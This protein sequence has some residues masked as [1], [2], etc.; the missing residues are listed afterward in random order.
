MI[1][2]VCWKWRPLVSY[3][4]SKFDAGHVNTLR[5]MV[6]RHYQKPH[7]FNCITDDPKGI[8][9]RVRIIPLWSDHS[10]LVSLHGKNNPSC[11]RR[12]RVFARDAAD[13]IGPRFI[14]IDLD[15]VI[16]GDLVPIFDRP[17]DFVMW[18][19][20]VGRNF[21]NGSMFMMTAGARPQVWETFEPVVS[22]HAASRAG[23]YGSDQAHICNVLGG[24]EARWT[25]ADGVYSWRN[26]VRY[27]PARLPDDA[28]MVFF[29]GSAGDPWAPNVQSAAPWIKRHYHDEEAPSCS[30]D[31]SIAASSGRPQQRP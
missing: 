9:S 8:D 23:F 24:D 26:H 2:V 14:S 22:S 1:D 20:M 18:E 7:R 13:L 12:L 31:R 30:P 15:V 21:Y 25:R 5:A 17:E 3:Y 29:H 4:R 19:G 6:A 27:R 11:F 28:R 16:A 10:S